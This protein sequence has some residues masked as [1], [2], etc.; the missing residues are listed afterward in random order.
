M[1]LAPGY[2]TEDLHSFVA[3]DLQLGIFNPSESEEIEVVRKPLYEAI[4]M[5]RTNDI[6]DAKTIARVFYYIRFGTV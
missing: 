3:V 6:R 1:Y 2:S 4:R 5:I